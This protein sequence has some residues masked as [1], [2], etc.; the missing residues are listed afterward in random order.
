VTARADTDAIAGLAAAYGGIGALAAG[1]SRHDL[2]AP[3]RCH[4]WIVADV[5]YHQL[6]DAQR[7]LAAF[8]S[9]VGGPADRD[10][11]SYWTGFGEEVAGTDPIPGIWAVK[12]SAAA[13]SDGRGAV[14]IWGDTA[15][16]AVEAA[17]R[18]DPDGFVA[19]QGHV[20]AVPDF[21]ATLVTEA[22]LHHLDMVVALPDAPR[23]QAPAV[24]IALETL[25]GLL[26]ARGGTRAAG[27]TDEEYL[28]VAAGR[29]PAPDGYAS[30]LPLIS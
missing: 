3:T 17:R 8:A 26:A 4:G 20:L 25:D 9:P 12:R 5:L 24:A 29:E 21:V 11:L 28:L 23:P 27:W 13:F 22:V 14:L 6:G 10:R 16:A 15:P 19:T 1:L 2:L 7:A 30:L 18:A